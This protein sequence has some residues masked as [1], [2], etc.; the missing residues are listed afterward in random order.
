M[1]SVPPRRDGAY[2]SSVFA[3]VASCMFDVPS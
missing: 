2:P 3:I 1:G